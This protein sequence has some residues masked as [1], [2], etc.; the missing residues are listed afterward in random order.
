MV[1]ERGLTEGVERMCRAAAQAHVRTGAPIT[2]H[3]DAPSQSGLP[4]LDLF[5]KEGVDLRKV[6]VGHAG[7]S[8]DLDY[9]R[10]LADTGAILGMDR[11]G[12]DM[13]NPTEQRV[14]TIAALCE[15]GYADRMVLSHDTACFMDYFGGQWDE[16]VP[17][18]APNWRYD[19]IHDDVLPALRASGVTD[20]HLEQLLV[21]NPARYFS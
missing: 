18:V 3:T 21:T 2:V 5:A 12:L 15:L 20:A 1:D 11:F 9:L 10:R 14:A 17:L 19:H 13:Y 7:D 8:N 16:G 6:V 4:A